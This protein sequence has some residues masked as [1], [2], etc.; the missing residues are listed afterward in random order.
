MHEVK[1]RSFLAMAVGALALPWL[2]KGKEPTAACQVVVHEP[3]KPKPRAWTEVWR[4]HG[5]NKNRR[6]AQWY[7]PGGISALIDATGNVNSHP[8]RG[9]GPGRVKLEQY[10]FTR[11]VDGW[12][13]ELTYKRARGR[14][15]AR[16]G[17]RT[18][19]PA[20]GP[21]ATDFNELLSTTDWVLESGAE[22]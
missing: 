16:A 4:T 19:R 5:A 17:K 1:R 20:V 22:A 11:L 18:T 12:R 8:F 21:Y 13:V 6:N 14:W 3:A 9:C 10:R 2:P 7:V 15:V